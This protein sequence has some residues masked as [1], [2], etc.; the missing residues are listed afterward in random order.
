MKTNEKNLPP[1]KKEELNRKRQGNINSDNQI[2]PAILMALRQGDHNAY[3]EIYLRYYKS[4]V[5]FT[6]ALIRSSED[7]EDI[8][9]DIF[10][11]VWENR[12]NLN[13][14]QC[15]RSYLFAA[16]KHLA[17]RYFRKKKS[18][19]NY[20]LYCGQQSREESSADQALSLKEVEM[21]T[22]QAISQMPPI[23]KKIFWMYY[24]ENLRY[25][26]IADKLNMNKATVANHLSH[27]KKDIRRVLGT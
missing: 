3:E 5:H 23:R 2:T 15:I 4:I 27:A 26:Q 18:E 17:M 13:P 20:L 11:S 6:N 8:A 19:S 25:D 24:H 16:A 12:K 9:H 21:L 1:M 10:I 7:A 22:Q 14:E